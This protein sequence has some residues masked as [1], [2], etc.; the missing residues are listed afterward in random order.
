[1]DLEALALTVDEL[2]HAPAAERRLRPP[3][4]RSLH[5]GRRW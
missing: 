5:A 3:L 2:V 4:R 1:M